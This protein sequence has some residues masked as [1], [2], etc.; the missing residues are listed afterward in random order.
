LVGVCGVGLFQSDAFLARRTPT[1]PIT[2][3]TKPQQACS[4]SW[5][6]KDAESEAAGAAFLPIPG[7]GHDPSDEAQL[8][9]QPGFESGVERDLSDRSS[10]EH[11]EGPHEPLLFT[12]SR[13]R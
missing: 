5:R 11:A 3:A 1:A 10:S 7:V 8:F 12:G 4:E 13:H 9:R 6:R 2:L